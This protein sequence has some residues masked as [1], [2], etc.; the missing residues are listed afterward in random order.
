MAC[1]IVVGL[2]L[3]WFRIATAAGA[4]GTTAFTVTIDRDKIA[5]DAERARQKA[6]E[7]LHRG[8]KTTRAQQ[9]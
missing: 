8:A 5:S 4:P 3:G 9:K 2:C 1:M 6:S 7:L